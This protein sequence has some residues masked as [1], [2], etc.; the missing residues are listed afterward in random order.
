MRTLYE[1]RERLKGELADVERS[2]ALLEAR[3]TRGEDHA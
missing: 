3:H 1:L 2:I